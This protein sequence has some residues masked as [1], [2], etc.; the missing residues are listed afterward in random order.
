V[1]ECAFFGLPA[2]RKLRS[3]ALE[4]VGWQV[5]C[6]HGF[7]DFLQPLGRGGPV[8]SMLSQK[9]P[10]PFGVSVS[11]SNLKTAQ[12]LIEE[13]FKTKFALENQGA[14]KGFTMSGKLTGGVWI[15]FLQT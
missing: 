1:K 5:S 12:G 6:G 13:S 10:G 15:Q 11:V 7:I 9:G 4:A 2:G 3:S 14:H 8:A